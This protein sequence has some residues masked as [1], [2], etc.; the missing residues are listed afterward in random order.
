MKRVTVLSVTPEGEITLSGTASLPAGCNPSSPRHY[1]VEPEPP[2]TAPANLSPALRTVFDRAF[3]RDMVAL[4]RG[5]YR[6]PGN[7]LGLMGKGV[8]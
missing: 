2:V 1:G 7:V 3:D 5:T 4:R 8:A 6:H